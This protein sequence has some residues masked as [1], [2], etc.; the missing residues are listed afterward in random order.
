[1]AVAAYVMD[2]CVLTD[3]MDKVAS[4]ADSGVN[5]GLMLENEGLDETMVDKEGT[6]P[7]GWHHAEDE[8]YNF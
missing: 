6:V 3:F 7:A 2:S 5:F 4:L 1:M 8:E